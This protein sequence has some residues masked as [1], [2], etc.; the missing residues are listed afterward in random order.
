MEN[1]GITLI[2]LVPLVT[3]RVFAEERARGTDE[4]LL[5]TALGP[6][7]IV[8]AKFAAT[9]L[10]VVLMMAV[11]FVYPAMA[12]V[13]GG[14]GMQHLAAVFVGLTLH[15]HRPRLDRPRL[16]GLDLEPARGGGLGL[17]GGLRAL[18]LRVDEVLPLRRRRERPHPRPALAPPA[19]RELRRGRRE[20]SA[21][22]PT[23]SPSPPSPPRWRASPSSA[24]G[25][26]MSG[27]AVAGWIALAFGAGA[28]YAIGEAGWFGRANL[29][30]RRAGPRCRRSCAPRCA[31][32]A[33]RPPAFRG[34]RRAR[35]PRRRRWR[36]PAASPSSGSPPPRGSSSTGPSSAAS[37]SRRRR[38][39]R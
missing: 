26:G 24:P 12:I 11:S 9:F 18:G 15:A 25:G 20:R 32:A 17:G 16:L 28:Y 4:L 19:L 1:L 23:S 38:G 8:A 22:S 36:S 10:F 7:R 29:V 31:R 35:S 21:T 6:G 13:Q 33:L 37:S 34:R 3:M 30:A 27:L 39:R 14:L 5:T 2:G